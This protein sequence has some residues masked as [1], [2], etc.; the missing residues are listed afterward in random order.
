VFNLFLRSLS[1]GL[2]AFV[3][4]AA[5]LAWFRRTDAAVA[6]ALRS[7]WVTTGPKAKEFEQAFSCKPEAKMVRSTEQRCEVW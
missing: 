4:V 1:Q 3:P 2:Q 5:A 7:G 6:S